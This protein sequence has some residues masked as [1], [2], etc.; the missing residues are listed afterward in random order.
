MVPA[1]DHGGVEALRCQVLGEHLSQF[2]VVVND[3]N[4]VHGVF[5]VTATRAFSHKVT[6]PGPG[7]QRFTQSYL[8]TTHERA[9]I[10]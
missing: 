9:G 10:G 7:L 6:G 4:S 1:M 3:K 5:S 2:D 8:W